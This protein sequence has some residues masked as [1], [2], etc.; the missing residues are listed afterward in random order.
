M[1]EHSPSRIRLGPIALRAC[2]ALGQPQPKRL[3]FQRIRHLCLQA[4]VMRS[5][6]KTNLESLC[7]HASRLHCLTNLQLTDWQLDALPQRCKPH[8]PVCV[9]RT[10]CEGSLDRLRELLGPLVAGMPANV[11]QLTL[12]PRG[13]WRGVRM[14]W[15]TIYIYIYVLIYIETKSST[16]QPSRQP[17]NHCAQQMWFLLLR[18]GLRCIYIYII[19]IYIYI[20]KK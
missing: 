8:P 4:D 19:R 17:A 12:G 18:G 5:L 20:Y 7:C 9:H 2:R 15:V 3:L 6:P 10:T 16:S 11:R 14:A 1:N 13:S